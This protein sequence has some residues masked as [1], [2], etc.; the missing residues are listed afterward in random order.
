VSV[1]KKLRKLKLWGRKKLLAYLHP[2]PDPYLADVSL[3]GVSENA[4]SVA[5][6]I[7]GADRQSALMIYGVTPRCGTNYVGP[8]VALHPDLSPWPNRIHEIPY[9]RLTNYILEFEKEFF[10][11]CKRNIGKLGENDFLAIF[12]A[13]FIGYM[14]SYMADPDKKMLLK[15]PDMRFLAYFPVV[16]PNEQLLLLLRDGRDVVYSTL[17]SWP[18]W[19][20]VDA[21]RHWEKSARLMLQ[22][23]S[24]HKDNPQ[25]GLFK[26]EDALSGPE[27][28]IREVCDKYSLD[29]SEFPYDRI[30]DLKIVGS[31]TDSRKDGHVD[32]HHHVERSSNFKPTGRWQEW[33]EAKKATFKKIAGQTLL[34]A[35]YCDDLNW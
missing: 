35:G 15:E 5:K 10:R 20:F 16:F 1:I 28:F 19:S 8:L 23:Y 25:Y 4:K 24:Q 32:W 2:E 3:S 14:H 31:S 9:L 7:R 26:Y 17:K 27:N 34:D 30:D 11:D 18:G 22:F 21:C 12:G 6:N 29:S 33:T 13:S